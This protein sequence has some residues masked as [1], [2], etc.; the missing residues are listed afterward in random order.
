MKLRGVFP[1]LVAFS[2]LTV[3]FADAPAEEM[4]SAANQA[5]SA[6]RDEITGLARLARE[7]AARNELD[8]AEKFYNKLLLINAPEADK[9][10]SLLEMFDNY[11]VKKVYSKAITVGEKLQQMFP[12]DPALPEVLLKLG[13]LYR[14]TGAYQLAIGRFYNV[15]NSVL[16]VDQDEFA[17][18]KTLATRA[19]FEIAETFMAEGDYAQAQRVYSMLDRLELSSDDRARA[20]FK[21]GYSQFLLGNYAATITTARHFFESYGDTIYAPECHY[22]LSMALKARH[23]PEQ[24]A[25]EVLALLRV[26][27]KKQKT[28]PA[29]WVYWQRK[30]GNQIANELYEQGEMLRALSIYQALAKLDNDPGWQWPVIYQMGLCFE[31]LRLPD[32]AREAYNYIVAER[33]KMETAGTPI[34]ADLT[35]TKEMA[36]WRSEHLDWQQT[37]KTQLEDLLGPKTLPED[38]K[39]TALP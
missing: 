19:Q 36:E 28:D 22:V 35:E 8:L 4:P 24:A 29:R 27:S 7:A 39:V 30:T 1:F 15:L 12:N 11:R 38:V 34:G 9:K 16:R 2:L 37:T 13:L 32:R 18:Y 6:A 5:N 3:A 33:K 14:E 25:E 21:L 20:Q 23:Q 17:K 10:Q 31:R 26:E